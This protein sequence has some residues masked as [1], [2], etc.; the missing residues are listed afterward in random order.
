MNCSPPASSVL[1]I[2]QARV[3]EKGGLPFPSPVDLPDPG[4][5]PVSSTW[6][7]VSLPLSHQGSPLKCL[8]APSGIIFESPK[9][10]ELDMIDD[11]LFLFDRSEN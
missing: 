9:I 2:L 10:Y 1:G 5:E 4:I 3:L 8:I 7:V 6:Q 11:K